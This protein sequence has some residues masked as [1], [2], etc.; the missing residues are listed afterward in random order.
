MYYQGKIML[1]I[2]IGADIFTFG[3]KEKVCVNNYKQLFK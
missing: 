3:Y 1:D 2:F